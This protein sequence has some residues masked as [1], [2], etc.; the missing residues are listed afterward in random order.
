MLRTPSDSAIAVLAVT[1]QLATLGLAA[2]TGV[3]LASFG[4]G[5]STPFGMWLA[6]GTSLAA[7]LGVTW[8]ASRRLR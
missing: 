4:P 8:L 7:G 6:F 5:E 1:G 3:R 2:L